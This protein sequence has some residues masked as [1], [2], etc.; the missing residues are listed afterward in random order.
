MSKNG[1]NSKSSKKAATSSNNKSKIIT[2]IVAIVAI[3]LILLGLTCCNKD[4]DPNKLKGSVGKKDKKEEIKKEK[5][6]TNKEVNVVY[7]SIPGIMPVNM[8]YST[9]TASEVI[10]EASEEKDT[11]APVV[12]V[13]GNADMSLEFGID[14]YNEL[15][16]TYTDNKDGSGN[17]D[18][19]LRITLEGNKVDSVDTN[20]IGT[21]TLT[22]V[23]TDAAGNVGSAVRTVIVADT[24]GPEIS[25][26]YSKERNGDNYNNIYSFN[27]NDISGI[28]IVKFAA[29]LQGT[30]LNEEYFASNGEELSAPYSKQINVVGDYYVYSEDSLGNKT[31]YKVNMD[32][33][34][35]T[36]NTNLADSSDGTNTIHNTRVDIVAPNGYEVTDVRSL[37]GQS[38]LSSVTEE[39]FMDSENTP[40]DPSPYNDKYRLIEYGAVNSI[41][42]TEV[43]GSQNL[44][45][46]WYYIYYN[47]LN[48]A[49]GSE[50]AYIT[51][52][53]K[54]E[55]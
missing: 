27:I 54:M 17:I 14:T 35:I 28:A 9:E 43:T 38:R 23:Y 34:D 24:K 2:I 30:G 50:Q 42:I 55:R 3:I 7:E 40:T 41:V 6:K 44:G 48:T 45:D 8:V 22:Y 46:C 47:T 19:P 52:P 29:D 20:V 37:N 12:T 49:D 16:A 5:D 51:D 18:S 25:A 1:K 10:A 36:T 32:C 26:S 21:Y 31:I 33:Q 53:I 4:T 11:T 15:G 39:D 13:V